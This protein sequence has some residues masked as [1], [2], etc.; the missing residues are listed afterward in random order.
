MNSEKKNIRDSKKILSRTTISY[1]DRV[2][3]QHIRMISERSCDTEDNS[4]LI[5]EI[6]CL[7]ILKNIL[8][9][10]MI[11]LSIFFFFLW[12]PLI[13]I[14][15]LH[16][17]H[18]IMLN[19]WAL[20]HCLDQ[21]YGHYRVRG[22]HGV[23]NVDIARLMFTVRGTGR[24]SFISGKSVHNQ[25]YVKKV[26]CSR[27]IYCVTLCFILQMLVWTNWLLR[28]YLVMLYVVE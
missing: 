11:K 6:N 19:K 1:T 28:N 4:A 2:S 15:V 17:E 9:C 5:T 13:F 22:D 23:E 27:H 20:K 3:N 25:R 14:N 18:N 16:Q 26:L 10:N 12:S 21:L 7:S 8:N 24:S